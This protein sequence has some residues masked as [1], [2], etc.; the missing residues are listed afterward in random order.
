MT[1]TAKQLAAELFPRD[2]EAARAAAML[3]QRALSE[4]DVRTAD[5]ERQLEE[6]K[7][8]NDALLLEAAD[9]DHWKASAEARL[10]SNVAIGKRI[11]QVIAERD[12]L[13]E[14]LAEAKRERDAE[15]ARLKEE[16]D[17]AVAFANRVERGEVSFVAKVA[18]ETVLIAGLPIGKRSNESLSQAVNRVLT[19]RDSF[20]YQLEI[21]AAIVGEPEDKNAPLAYVHAVEKYAAQFL[22][23]ERELEGT[24]KDAEVL[25]LAWAGHYANSPAY[26]MGGQVHEKHQRILDRIKTA[27]SLKQA[28]QPTESDQ[29]TRDEMGG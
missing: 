9:A 19:E 1:D 24:F 13:R 11:E 26:G 8:R 25:A 12:T 3:I 4:K 18:T 16:R 21:I 27:L 17:K 29:W 7:I 23:V 6:L 28:E 22:Q 14:Q 20:R 15:V 2:D 10:E 5:L